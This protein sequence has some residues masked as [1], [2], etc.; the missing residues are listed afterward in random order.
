M[1]GDPYA[2]LITERG[3]I[4]L[5][6]EDCGQLVHDLKTPF[7][8][9]VGL[10]EAMKVMVRD[11]G[12]KRLLSMINRAGTR[13]AEYVERTLEIDEL[14]RGTMFM[15][16]QD[17][18]VG[19][20]ILEAVELMRYAED[21]NGVPVRKSTVEL[22]HDCPAGWS[23][24][25]GPVV[26]GDD[27]KIS[28]IIYH[29]IDNA[30]RYTE[31]GT[32]T[33]SGK[34]DADFVT[35]TVS[36]T[37]IGID[38]ARHDEI[39]IPFRRLAYPH[40]GC[41]GLGLSVVLETLHLM[42]GSVA[43]HSLGRGQG[44]TVTV[45]IP[46]KMNSPV[47]LQTFDRGPEGFGL[48]LD[49]T[50]PRPPQRLL[51]KRTVGLLAHE[52]RIPFL[53]VIGCSDYLVRTEEKK[54][55]QKQLGMINRCGVRLVDVIDVVR[56]AALMLELP[57]GLVVKSVQ[58]PML[59][60]NI[61]K[62]LDVAK[63]K[64]NQPMKKREVNFFNE[65][66]ASLP[67]IQG[68]ELKLAKIIEHVAENALKFT[69]KGHVRIDAKATK[70]M[71]TLIVEDTGIGIPDEDQERVFQPF[72]RLEPHNYYGLGLGLTVVYEIVKLAGGSIE[73]ESAKD[74]GTTFRIRLPTE[75][76]KTVFL[77]HLDAVFVKASKRS[78]ADATSADGR[79]RESSADPFLPIAA[80]SPLLATT[81]GESSPQAPPSS[82]TRSVGLLDVP[83]QHVES[84]RGDSTTGFKAEP[85]SAPP[86]AA[87][88][89]GQTQEPLGIH[90]VERLKSELGR[91]QQ[92]KTETA[93]A[94]QDWQ[95]RCEALVK[96][97]LQLRREMV[98]ER[99]RSAGEIRELSSELGSV[100][101]ESQ[102]LQDAIGR[103]EK[104]VKRLEEERA[105]AVA[106]AE[107]ANRQFAA[108]KKLRE[109]DRG[110]ASTH[111]AHA[112]E[113]SKLQSR[114]EVANEELVTCRRELKESREEVETLKGSDPTEVNGLVAKL[115]ARLDRANETIEELREEIDE[116]ARKRAA[117][118]RELSRLRNGRSEDAV[119]EQKE[120]DSH[121]F[122]HAVEQLKDVA[123]FMQQEIE[124]HVSRRGVET[125][126]ALRCLREENEKL[127][128]ELRMVRASG[129]ESQHPKDCQEGGDFEELKRQ[130]EHLRAE[131]GHR[132]A[133]ILRLQQEARR[134]RSH[135]AELSLGL[136]QKE[137]EAEDH[138]LRFEVRAKVEQDRVFIGMVYKVG[139]T[140]TGTLG[141]GRLARTAQYSDAWVTDFHPYSP[142]YVRLRVTDSAAAIKLERGDVWYFLNPELTPED[143]KVVISPVALTV[144]TREKMLKIGTASGVGDCE[145]VVGSKSKQGCI[146]PVNSELDRSGLCHIHLEELRSKSMNSRTMTGGRLPVS[147]LG[148]RLSTDIKMSDALLRPSV[149]D[150]LK[151]KRVEEAAERQ[152]QV[153]SLSLRLSRQRVTSG[154]CARSNDG[155]INAVINDFNPEQ[156]ATSV[157]PLLGRGLGEASTIDFV[158][159]ENEQRQPRD[160][161]PLSSRSPTGRAIPIIPK[162]ALTA[163]NG[164]NL[165]CFD[166]IIRIKSKL[167]G[168]AANEF[169]TV[170]MLKEISK[171][172]DDG[173]PPDVIR[174]SGIYAAVES[175]AGSTSSRDIVRPVAETVAKKL[176][177]RCK[178][179][180]QTKRARRTID[181]ASK[182]SSSGFSLT[183]LMDRC[184][185]GNRMMPQSSLAAGKRKRE[186][187]AETSHGGRNTKKQPSSKVKVA[188]KPTAP[189]MSEEE[190]ARLREMKSILK[191]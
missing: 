23:E 12:K 66:P 47:P 94:L 133:R 4:W 172:T 147:L 132:S 24:G 117:L 108:E 65:C 171:L 119:V 185:R 158:V 152:G 87:E 83:E 78:A 186:D 86:A 88:E 139:A 1:S 21:K 181:V 75:S 124:Q 170:A 58:I 191:R 146:Y 131:L 180:L 42:S 188:K 127:R 17:V 89:E 32:V 76:P 28:R 122:L 9:V 163:D 13:L 16:Q 54:P 130:N 29:I 189:P 102:E 74:K 187:E 90:E 114:L 175:L 129:E 105:A 53:G 116:S 38:P 59:V 50:Q 179:D 168:S 92:A 2:D 15:Q 149:E 134:L 178:A 77:D 46:I 135:I 123:S 30:L 113:M 40:D 140:R 84:S 112:A 183:D 36:D 153:K 34:T 39:F 164:D 157:V 101:K 49:T 138:F 62:Q 73:I 120:S 173:L 136:Q 61:H 118:S 121:A 31:S 51:M 67:D 93:A 60:E 22:V 85:L 72:V 190:R 161:G 43:V 57:A 154:E 125:S 5:G 184:V 18:D 174:K 33:V 20:S 35:V 167:N 64:R 14:S 70:G 55:L 7:N 169:D 141:K 44:T 166:D 69:N 52:L 104:N 148:N 159:K 27:M 26:E 95:Q 177:E 156:T 142:T 91:Q 162:M 11:E 56:D 126:E 48:Y 165:K 25:D 111:P 63:D 68:E 137:D 109:K 143:D 107:K 19:L 98:E 71:V 151:S 82:N 97:N 80:A 10:T 128:T 155:Y 106:G 176:E 79:P 115:Q 3:D 81:P 103:Q 182:I 41:L 6:R 37:G 145:A 144:G 100:K 99:E 110:K 96:D 160:S 45:R 8:G 150:A